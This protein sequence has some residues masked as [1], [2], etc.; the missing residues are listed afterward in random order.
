MDYV[1][2]DDLF[3][4]VATAAEKAIGFKETV[5][6]A[7]NGAFFGEPDRIRVLTLQLDD[8]RFAIKMKRPDGAVTYAIWST[9][10][11]GP[12]EPGAWSLETLRNRLGSIQTVN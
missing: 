8:D 5:I 1:G 10:S 3:P 6:S 11:G 7:P 4:S 2:N 12:V 9:K